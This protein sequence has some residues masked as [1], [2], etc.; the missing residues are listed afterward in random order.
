MLSDLRLI[1]NKDRLLYSLYE[2]IRNDFKQEIKQRPSK[3]EQ[4][5]KITKLVESNN[6][7]YIIQAF[8]LATVLEPNDKGLIAIVYDKV[9]DLVFIPLGYQVEL[10]ENQ[11]RSDSHQDRFDLLQLIW[12]R[13]NYANIMDY[14]LNGEVFTESQLEEKI[15]DELNISPWVVNNSSTMFDMHEIIEINTKQLL[16]DYNGELTRNGWNGFRAWVTDATGA[17]YQDFNM[18]D[19]EID[20]IDVRH[21]I[22]MS[23]VIIDEDNPV[24]RNLFSLSFTKNDFETLGV[25]EDGDTIEWIAQLNFLSPNGREIYSGND[26]GVSAQLRRVS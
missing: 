8:E 3:S 13:Y 6:T 24:Q 5:R 15:A 4:G 1:S 7:E 19:I 22:E 12:E 18:V 23:D 17:H 20:K 9:E 26:V 10:W 25:M 11:N 21:A 2:Q 16:I 14:Y